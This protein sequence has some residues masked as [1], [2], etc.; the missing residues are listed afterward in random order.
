VACS[1]SFFAYDF[2]ALASDFQGLFSEFLATP[3]KPLKEIGQFLAAREDENKR[4]DEEYLRA[5]KTE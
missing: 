5:L 2:Q 3:P 1:T 4:K